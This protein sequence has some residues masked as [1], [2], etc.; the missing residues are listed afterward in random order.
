MD[1]MQQILFVELLGGLGDV[2][3]ALPAIHALKRSHPAAFLTVLTFAPGS[4]LLDS[5]PLI[6][7]VL[8]SPPGEARLTLETLLE[9]ECFDLIVSDSSY[10]G[11]ADLIRHSGAKQVITNL[12]RSPP[13]DELVSDRF[14]KILLQEGV[15]TPTAISSAPCLHLTATERQHARQFLGAAFRP[16]IVLCVDAGMPIKRWPAENFVAVGQVLQTR[17]GATILVAEGAEP[18]LAKAI[19]TAI[20][21][22]ARILP[23]GSL[24]YL[25]AIL[26]EADLVIAADTGPARIAAALAVPTITLFGPSWHGRYGQPSP[27]LNLQSYPTCP[28][29]NVANFTEQACWYSGQCPLEWNTCLENIQPD[30]VIDAAISLLEKRGAYSQSLV[31]QSNNADFQSPIQNPQSKILPIPNPK[32]LSPNPFRSVH[33]LL[34]LRL[35]NIG[36]VVMTSPAIQALKENLPQAKITFMASPAGSLVAP[37][38]PGVDD[39]LTWRVLWQDLGRLDFNPQR[40]WDLIQTLKSRQFDAAIIFTSF[41]QSPHPAALI[42]A[43]AGIPL[44]L[45]ESKEVDGGTLTHAVVS[46]PDEIHQV[47]RNLRLL[48]SVGFQVYDRR[49]TLKW[50]DHQ[51]PLPRPYILLNPW[52]SCQA[53]NYPT[54]RFTLAAYHLSLKT[55]W[56]IVVTGVE[57]DRPLARELLA[58]LGDRAIDLIGKTTLPELIALI[59]EAELVLTNNTSTMHIA[60]ATQTPSVILFSGTEQKSQWQPRHSPNRLLRRST[61]CSPCYAF[62][63]PYDLQCLDIAPKEVIEAALDLFACISPNISC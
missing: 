30:R 52:T 46:A 42:C 29:R 22:S 36:D 62:T 27:H 43:L 47:E 7:R 45:G 21:G 11:M 55:G 4:K 35:D 3:I 28:E 57:K 32:S 16:L 59:A 39:V 34:V 54:E 38:L 51:K 15:I 1:E 20:A 13:P 18:A 5:D 61:V 24:R 63:C 41:S 33:N 12:W 44:R 40:E 19:V 8:E 48:E 17:Y 10:E 6:D 14:L 49:L 23:R 56:P 53:R 26:A 50:P 2:I 25:A 60:D 31:D 9:Q 58:Q 37:L